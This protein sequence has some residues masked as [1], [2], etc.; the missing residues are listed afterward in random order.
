MWN[1][2]DVKTVTG[3]IVHCAD[4]CG[5]TKIFEVAKNWSLRVNQEF[6]IQVKNKNITRKL[7]S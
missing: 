3:M 1:D 6:T 4:V 5:P 7:T 2:D